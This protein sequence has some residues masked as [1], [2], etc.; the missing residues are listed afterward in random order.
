MVGLVQ[1]DKA[2][3]MLCRNENVGGVVYADRFV[4]WRMHDQQCLAEI[5]CL[6][7][8][9][10][11]FQ[12]L[13]KLL[14]DRKSSACKIDVTCPLGPDLVDRSLEIVNDVVGIGRCTDCHD[15]HSARLKA[16]GADAIQV[17]S[18]GSRQLDAA[19]PPILML[20]KIRE[21][22]GPDFPLFYDSGVRSGEDVVKACA[23]GADFVFLGR[24]LQF[25][26]AAGGEA[27]LAALWRVLLQEVELTLAQIGKTGFS[28]LGDALA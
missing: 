19:P 27:G 25:A 6:S 24:I 3:G 23:M 5:R 16:E 4:Q 26:Y 18:H 28:D 2:L 1:R 15:P 17:S 10:L 13:Q 14:A 21:A 11:S 7:P 9:R 22:V 20:P 12:I 8:D